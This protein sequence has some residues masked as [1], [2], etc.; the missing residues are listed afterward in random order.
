[1]E[2]DR[3]DYSALRDFSTSV[4]EAL[5]RPCFAYAIKDK[6]ER[7]LAIQYD[8]GTHRTYGHESKQWLLGVGSSRKERFTAAQIRQVFEMAADTFGTH[9]L[10]ARGS[11]TSKR[12]VAGDLSEP[13]PCLF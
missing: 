1:M 13:Q 3:P 6:R 9:V 11:L 8:D 4:T 7:R 2:G 12:N 10:P 5:G